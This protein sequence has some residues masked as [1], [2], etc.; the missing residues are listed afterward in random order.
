MNW[1]GGSSQLTEQ[2]SYQRPRIA[3]NCGAHRQTRGPRWRTDSPTQV[4]GGEGGDNRDNPGLRFT[5]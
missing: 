2:F 3:S 4:G 5:Y 1:R